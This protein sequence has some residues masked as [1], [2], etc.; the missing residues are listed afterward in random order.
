MRNL[1]FFVIHWNTTPS[2]DWPE[3]IQHRKLS[4]CLSACLLLL[5]LLR[6]YDNVIETPPCSCCS[7]AT[8]RCSLL[9][10]QLTSSVTA[11]HT[12]THTLYLSIHNIAAAAAYQQHLLLLGC[13]LRHPKSTLE[14]H[15][16]I[17]TKVSNTYCYICTD[18]CDE[19]NSHLTHNT[20]IIVVVQMRYVRDCTETLLCRTVS[21]DKIS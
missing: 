10:I 14:L 6:T 11:L 7:V 8:V 16:S 12:H 5:L 18:G 2:G 13:G 3:K 17:S 4:V 1:S 9:L 19:S 20:V 15:L 21:F